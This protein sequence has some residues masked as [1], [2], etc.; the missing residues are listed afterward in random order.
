LTDAL[1]DRLTSSGS[2][3]V[4][5]GPSAFVLRGHRTDTRGIA[6][7]L[8]V[9]NIL[10]SGVLIE[11]NAM[12]VSMK[13]I[14]G[15]DGSVRWSRTYQGNWENRFAIQDSIEAEVPRELALRVAGAQQGVRHK[16]PRTH[17]AYE[18]YLRGRHQWNAPA[19]Q[20]MMTMRTA[21]KYF[22]GALDEDS[23]YADAYAGLA[24][25]YLIIATGNLTDFDPRVAGDS[26]R[27]AATKAV[28]YNDS[29]PEAHAALSAVKWLIDYDWPAADA[30]LK[31]AHDLNPYYSRTPLWASVY[32]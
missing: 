1:I 16:F 13:L 23:T 14:N 25:S 28:F 19:V 27:N 6:D 3:R 12:R 17:R 10:A 31:K 32:Y 15:A 29:L 9:S 4:I 22:Q 24:A 5:Q 2:L 20:P 7:S 21:I 8:G 18:L 11:G 30:E 26:A